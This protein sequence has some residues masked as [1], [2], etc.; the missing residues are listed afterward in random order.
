MD[1]V[2]LY[3]DFIFLFGAGACE[4]N[5]SPGDL[6]E[7]DLKAKSQAVAFVSTADSLGT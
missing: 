7:G 1:F 6:R 3:A 5:S 4:D 2:S